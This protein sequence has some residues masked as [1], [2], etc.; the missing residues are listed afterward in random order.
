MCQLTC[1]TTDVKTDCFS[2]QIG[3]D[4]VAIEEVSEKNH[5]AMIEHKGHLDSH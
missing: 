4:V 2:N 3:I 1:Q 5:K